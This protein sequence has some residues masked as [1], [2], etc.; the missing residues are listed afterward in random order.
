MWAG[1]TSSTQEQ[2]EE[3]YQELAKKGILDEIEKLFM[4]KDIKEIGKSS[5]KKS[6]K[7]QIISRDLM[8]TMQISLAKFSTADAEEITRMIIHCDKDTLDNSNVM[9]FLQTEHLSTIPDN[10]TKT[11]GPYSRDFTG[12]DALKTPPEQDPNELTREDQIYLHT[13]YELHHYWKARMRALALTRNFEAEYDEISSK[14]KQVVAVSESL[15]DS[16]KLMPVFGLILDI[17]NYMNDSNKQAVGFKLSSLARLGMVKDDKNESTLMDYVER[18][19]RRQYPQYE[20][21][22]EDIGGV[23]AAQKLNVEQLQADAKRYIDNIS[24][25]QASL[26][27]GNLSDPR[28]FHPE[29]RVSQVVQRSMKEARRKAE[30]MGL[31]LEEMKRVFDDILT[32]FGDDN[33]DENARREFFGKLANFVLEYKVRLIPSSF[34]QP[35]RRLLILAEIPREKHGPRGYVAAQRGQHA[36]QT[37]RHATRRRSYNCGTRRRTALPRRHRSHGHSS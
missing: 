29:D 4:A 1:I 6:D 36:P 28:K 19:V 26:D 8:H 18:V 22:I 31:Y 32:F 21:F 3:K 2:K 33:K 14:L 16:V 35:A 37:G 7:K 10:V 11:M 25:V 12:P 23:V 30:Q 13:A 27:A 15:R 17:G 9:D 20:G 24:N 34:A 5:A